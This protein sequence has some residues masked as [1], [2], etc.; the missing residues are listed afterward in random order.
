MKVFKTLLIFIISFQMAYA[1]TLQEGLSESV[2]NQYHKYQDEFEVL[3]DHPAFD[4]LTILDEDLEPTNLRER[5]VNGNSEIMLKLETGEGMPPLLLKFK[6][7][8]SEDVNLFSLAVKV[9]NLSERITL[10]RD[11]VNFDLRDPEAANLEIQRLSES[12]QRKIVENGPESFETRIG[13]LNA[14]AGWLTAIAVV[15]AV[16]SFIGALG[17]RASNKG[18]GV[19]ALIVGVIAIMLPI[20]QILSQGEERDQI[21]KFLTTTGS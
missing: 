4:G 12:L 8:H 17:L 2:L 19:A 20:L 21:E 15:G 1:S 18:P 16:I 13:Q 5:L 6:P 10:A 7:N 9:E 3:L 14:A 11:F